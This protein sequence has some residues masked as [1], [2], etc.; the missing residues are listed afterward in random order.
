MI[1]RGTKIAIIV[2]IIVTLILIGIAIP[3]FHNYF[4]RTVYHVTALADTTEFKASDFADK[5]ELKLNKN[6][7]FHVY[8]YHNE[9]GLSLAGIGTYK[10]DGDNYVLT[11]IQA[12]A[13]DNNGDVVDYTDRCGDITCKRSG[14]RI[15]FTDHKYQTFYFG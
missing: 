9:K 2:T 11:F 7:T 10:K 15:K 1:R 3:L 6:G 13:R 5:S 12:V 14:S 4:N 8:I